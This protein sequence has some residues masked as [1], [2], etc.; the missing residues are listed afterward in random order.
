M[1]YYITGLTHV[2]RSP[3]SVGKPY[4]KRRTLLAVFALFVFAQYGDLSLHESPQ[5]RRSDL[6][7][8]P[9]TRDALKA[10]SAEPGAPASAVTAVR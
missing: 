2:S 5:A 4:L 10:K 7:D 8:A 9:A 1:G 3:A 6:V